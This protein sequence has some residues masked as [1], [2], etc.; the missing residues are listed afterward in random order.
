MAQVISLSMSMFMTFCLGR[1]RVRCA[2]V[3]EASKRMYFSTRGFSSVF[4]SSPK[5]GSLVGSAMLASRVLNLR[6]SIRVAK[7]EIRNSY[8]GNRAGQLALFEAIFE[9][10][11]SRFDF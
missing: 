11:I 10:R 6:F 4:G 2:T 1:L 7:S 9:F 5:M 3:P 8:L